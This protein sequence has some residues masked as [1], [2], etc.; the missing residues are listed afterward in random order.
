MFQPGVWYMCELAGVFMYMCVCVGLCFACL[1]ASMSALY[2][3][4]SWVHVWWQNG[5]S[6]KVGGAGGHVVGY[7]GGAQRLG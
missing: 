4:V 7:Q 2:V 6:S 3:C 1:H 5:V